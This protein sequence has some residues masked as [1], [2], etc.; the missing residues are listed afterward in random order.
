MR[1]ACDLAQV[2]DR[3]VVGGRAGLEMEGGFQEAEGIDPWD[4]FVAERRQY[5]SW[6]IIEGTYVIQSAM[7]VSIDLNAAF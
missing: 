3:V 1:N 7:C 4:M 2:F 5:T 6:G